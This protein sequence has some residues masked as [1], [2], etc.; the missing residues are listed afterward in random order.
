MNERIFEL[1]EQAGLSH[2]PSD[3][4]DMADLYQGADFELEKFAELI[5]K[6]CLGDLKERIAIRYQGSEKDRDIA[7]GM[8]IVYLDIVDKFGVDENLEFDNK[9]QFCYT[10]FIDS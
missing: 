1:A 8:E 2:M 3:Y 5:I 7:Y 6:E 10:V 4:P 9:S